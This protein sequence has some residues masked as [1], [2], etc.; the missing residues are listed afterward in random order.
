MKYI[1]KIKILIKHNRRLKWVHEGVEVEATTGDR[2]AKAGASAVAAKY[3]GFKRVQCSGVKPAPHR[4][5]EALVMPIEDVVETAAPVFKR[6]PDGRGKKP[7][8]E[9]A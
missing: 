8:Y 6:G 7:P 4:D 9:P 3:P 1:A 5:E 2:A